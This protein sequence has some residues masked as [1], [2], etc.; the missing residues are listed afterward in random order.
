[1]VAERRERSAQQ[2]P[3]PPERGEAP[4]MGRDIAAR[5]LAEAAARERPCSVAAPGEGAAEG[6]AEG[7]GSRSQPWRAE[8]SKGP[9]N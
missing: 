9:R 4:G 1:M 8:N 5:R 6:G 2:P 3:R 7:R